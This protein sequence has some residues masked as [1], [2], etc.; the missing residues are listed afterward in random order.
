MTT[1]TSD[2]HRQTTRIVGTW[3]GLVLAA[4]VTATAVCVVDW[5]V[6]WGQS[7]TCY[8]APDPRDVRIGRAWLGGLLLVSLAPWSL[9][10]VTARRRLPVVVVGS[11]AVLPGLL[12]FLHGLTDGAWVG[13][14]CF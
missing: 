8:E 13:S 2:G 4:I 5:L 10:A 12:L 14:F 1:T 11:F 3:I 6:M 7:S 9:G